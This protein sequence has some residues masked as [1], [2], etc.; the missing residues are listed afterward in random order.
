[1]VE[2]RQQPLHRVVLQAAP[3]AVYEKVV[4]LDLNHVTTRQETL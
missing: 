3:P 1:M 4:G 2:A